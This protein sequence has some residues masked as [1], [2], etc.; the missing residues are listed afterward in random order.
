MQ[1][2]HER[3][4]SRGSFERGCTLNGRRWGEENN[5]GN[6]VGGC[7]GIVGVVWCRMCVWVGGVGC[8][9]GVV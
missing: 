4:Y 1:P 5:V 6:V 3:G 7:M 9:Y 8:V 2:M